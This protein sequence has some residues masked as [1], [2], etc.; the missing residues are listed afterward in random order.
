MP[1]PADVHGADVFTFSLDGAESELPALRQLLS[2]EERDRADRFV[3][4]QHA[5]RFVVGRATVRRI[6]ADLLACRPE[7]LVFKL[8]AYGKPAL[9]APGPTGL[10]F[11]LSHTGDVALL[12]VSPTVELGVDIEAV[13]GT[14]CE[15][16]LPAL[17][18][19]AREQATLGALPVNLQ[20]RAFYLGWT[21]K[22]AFVKA[23]GQGLSMPLKDFDVTL[24][25]AAAPRIE[26]IA[27]EPGAA[28][29][30]ALAH[31]D[32]PDGVV[33]AI[34]AE[35]GSNKIA[36]R[37]VRADIAVT[38]SGAHNPTLKQDTISHTILR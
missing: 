10:H 36:V 6:L 25:P 14:P 20:L 21:R 28:D 24:D 29:R 13:R 22:E 17:V 15:D 26:A 18:F 19:S 37:L 3:F 34:A 33:G 11:N 8:N 38:V 35:T 1:A 4:P 27:D 7:N 30:W 5:D 32:L 16:G 31:L 9:A 12:A 23:C 2:Q